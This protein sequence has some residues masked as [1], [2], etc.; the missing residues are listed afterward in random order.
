MKKVILFWGLMILAF[1]SGAQ[2]YER[3]SGYLGKKFLIGG[4]WFLSP[5]TQPQTAQ[6]SDHVTDYDDPSKTLNV[7]PHFHIEYTLG[8]Y[9]SI[10]VAAGKQRTSSRLY[11]DDLNGYYWGESFGN[12]QHEHSLMVITGSPDIHDLWYGIYLKRY[13]ANWGALAP[14]GAYFKIGINIHNYDIDFR[15]IRYVTNSY[16]GFGK[17]ETRYFKHSFDNGTVSIPEIEYCFGKSRPLTRRLIFDYSLGGGFLLTSNSNLNGQT[18]VGS[19][20][21]NEAAQAVIGEIKDRLRNGQLLKF[22]FTLSY[23][24]F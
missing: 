2:K 9:Y 6:E 18:N 3:V 1:C 14:V 11:I 22:S 5:S 21:G 12:G 20:D 7:M 19:G 15:K 24:I 13:L 4:G 23:L 17:Y 10:G 8:T 16:A